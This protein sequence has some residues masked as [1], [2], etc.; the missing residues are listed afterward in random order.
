M[1]PPR[2]HAATLTIG[3]CFAALM[4]LPVPLAAG[5]PLPER[6]PV[7]SQE[8]HSGGVEVPTNEPAAHQAAKA[9][10][11]FERHCAR[12]H[13]S[14][15][16]KRQLPAAGIANILDLEAVARRRDLVRPGY[17]EGSPLYVSMVT[18]HMPFDVFQEFAKGEEPSAGEIADVRAWIAE[19]PKSRA[20]RAHALPPADVAEIIRRDLAT[21][22]SSAQQGRRYLSLI[23]F[24]APCHGD[25]PLR[26]HIRA[27]T[28]LVNLLSRA[29]A[30]HRL[31][32][33]GP[34]SLILALDLE[35]IGWSS[36]DWAWLAAKWSSV[37]LDQA[38]SGDDS[39]SPLKRVLPA[40]WLAHK[41]M[42]PGI[43]ARLVR[44]PP[45]L[46][47]FRSAF[48]TDTAHPSQTQTYE[49]D[50]SKA[51]GGR[52]ILT[53]ALTSDA[54]VFWTAQDFAGGDRSASRNDEPEPLQTRAI[55]PLPNGFPAFA[56]YNRDGTSRRSAHK[57]ALPSVVAQGWAAG[58]GLGCLACHGGG[59]LGFATTKD[60]ERAAPGE[61][62]VRR[63][64]SDYHFAGRAAGLPANFE[65][66]GNDPVIALAQRY[67]R[68]LDLEAAADELGHP[69]AKLAQMLRAVDGGML[70]AAR[71]LLQGLVTRAEFEGLRRA[72]L[73]RRQREA[74]TQTHALALTNPPESRMHLS[75]WTEKAGYAKGEPLVLHA[76]TNA[77]CHLTLFSV[78]AHGDTVVIFPNEF[79][80][81]N[82]LKPGDTLNVPGSDSGYLLRVDEP[83]GESIVGVCM[84][85]ERNNPPGVYHDHELQPFT[86]LG[87]WGRHI[88][89]ALEDDAR[90]RKRAGK[91]TRKER[92]RRRRARRAKSLP[93]R[94]DKSP[95]AQDWAMIVIA[96]R[97]KET[98]A[99]GQPAAEASDDGVSRESGSRPNPLVSR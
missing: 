30:P 95:L 63:D 80:D 27:A 76:A 31:Q 9:L 23:D 75:L 70:P 88:A 67:A 50:N 39:E 52:R 86:L 85:G 90:E 71:R 44:L 16:L 48:G 24:I 14:R 94:A 98:A 42:D 60:S 1:R 78:D 12:C 33:V 97:K 29:K 13:D 34:E 91:K 38:A 66:E 96:R 82:L 55:F 3:G 8:T 46:A 35:R 2:L 93:Y 61:W 72:L 62:Q 18:R 17:P 41:A 19:L 32:P 21:L 20:C 43:Y 7:P 65:I 5:P 36:E 73:P 53:R 56:L 81:K 4:M 69:P 6:A 89:R 54:R 83:G 22:D 10:R 87:D 92:K 58:A 45:N 64:N 25:E 57:A 40:A 74:V 51:T 77:A 15:R 26:A 37:D 28:K 11:V 59:L 49:L 84:A 79:Q 47:A 68:N 99:A